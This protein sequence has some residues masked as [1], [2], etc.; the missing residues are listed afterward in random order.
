MDAHIF[1]SCT[2]HIRSASFHDGLDV[3]SKFILASTLSTN[4]G[5]NTALKQEEGNAREAEQAKACTQLL[6]TSWLWL[7]RDN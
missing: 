1:K 7:P 2:N 3:D 6:P 5:R 4:K